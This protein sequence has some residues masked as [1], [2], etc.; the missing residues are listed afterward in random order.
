MLTQDEIRTIAFGEYEA[1]IKYAIKHFPKIQYKGIP[2][3]ELVNEAIINVFDF[4]RFESKEQ[5][6]K[7]IQT[8][9]KTIGDHERR[10]LFDSNFIIKKTEIGEFSLLSLNKP[11]VIDKPSDEFIKIYLLFEQY[12][13]G[14]K[15]EKMVCNKCGFNVFWE[16]DNYKDRYK[17]KHCRHRMSLT[18]RTYIHGIK[19]KYSVFY[20]MCTKLLEDKWQTSSIFLGKFCG[21]TQT[22]AF[23]RKILIVSAGNNIQSLN[24]WNLMYKIL[25]NKEWDDQPIELIR[26]KKKFS[27]DDI[28]NI[29]RLVNDDV[30]KM[31]YI[32][33]M[34]K[35]DRSTIRKIAKGLAYNTPHYNQ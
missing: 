31:S 27:P 9:I 5:L 13:F 34:Y 22:T 25:S 10:L 16:L 26:R 24:R 21:V 14:E 2:H 3:D 18:S 32:C 20:K 6:I 15:K 12:R 29:R 8:S 28:Q 30:Y 1:F 19:L 7:F 4:N 11:F 23:K 33:D 17:C 35:T